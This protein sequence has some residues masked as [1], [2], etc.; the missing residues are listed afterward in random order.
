MVG[1]GVGM[2]L[3]AFGD[4]AVP[5]TFAVHTDD[6]QLG[7]VFVAQRWI[8]HRVLKITNA[9]LGEFNAGHGLCPSED[10]PLFEPSFSQ[11]MMTRSIDGVSQSIR[12]RLDAHRAAAEPRHMIH[13]CLDRPMVI[14]DDVRV[15]RADGD[16][17]RLL[18]HW[19]H[20]RVAT[21][22]PRHRDLRPLRGEKRRRER[23]KE[24]RGFH[25]EPTGGHAGGFR[26]HLVGCITRRV[27]AKSSYEHCGPSNLQSH[28]Q[29]APGGSH[30]GS[31]VAG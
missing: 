25:A 28:P 19:L 9:G 30:R 21:R 13:R 22:L 20:R 7:A 2:E 12:A 27:S 11:I 15:L 26:G 8:I 17:Q 24:Q 16:R 1:D 5:G 31:Q 14:P 23:E 6:Q 29:A 3:E 4:E 18:P 10:T